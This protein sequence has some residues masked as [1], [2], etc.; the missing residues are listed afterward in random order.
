MSSVRGEH[1]ALTN[2]FSCSVIW[3]LA[4]DPSFIA[5]YKLSIKQCTKHTGYPSVCGPSD[6]LLF[7]RLGRVAISSESSTREPSASKLT[8]AVGRNQFLEGFN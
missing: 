6:P 8:Q 2:S 4:C 1:C 7:I 3:F 5:Y